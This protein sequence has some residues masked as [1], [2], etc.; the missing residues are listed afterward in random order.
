MD[1]GSRG[2]PVLGFSF[3]QSTVP[4]DPHNTSLSRG[5]L[6]TSAVPDASSTPPETLCLFSAHRPLKPPCSL[7]LL[8]IHRELPTTPQERKGPLQLIRCCIPGAPNSS[9]CTQ[10]PNQTCGTGWL[11]GRGT[12]AG[13]PRPKFRRALLLH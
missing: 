1:A 2:A 7:I 11:P 5:R 10:R 12:C 13:I 9:W 8:P 3:A 6:C 4:P